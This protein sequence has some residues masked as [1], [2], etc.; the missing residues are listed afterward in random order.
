[1]LPGSRP[2]PVGLPWRHALMAL[3]V[4]LW[5]CALLGGLFL[6]DLW[7]WSAGLLYVGYDTWLIGYVAW[8]TWDLRPAGPEVPRAPSLGVIVPAR[9]EA[10]MLPACLDALLAQ[11]DPAERILLADDGSTDHSAVMLRSRYGLSAAPG[12]VH[13]TIHPGLS[14][15]RLPHGG[16]ARA[17]NAAWPELDTDLVVTLDADTLLAPE[18]LAAL[19]QAFGRDPELAAAGGVLKPRCGHGVNARLFEW[20]Q[21]FEY[22]RAFLSRAA[23]MRAD[24]L[25][26]VSGAFAVFRLEVLRKLGGFRDDSLVEDYELIHRLHRHA[27]D[28]GL[29][30]RVGVVGEARAVTD[31]PASLRSFLRQRRRW[32][33]G[34]LQTQFANRDMTGNP[35]YGAV[36]RLMLPVKTVD[37]L[38][39]LFGLTAF[40]LLLW[41]LASGSPVALPVLLVIGAKLLVD[42]CYHLW[43][44]H[45]YYRWLG[46]PMPPLSWPRA[47]AA[48]LAEP[49]SFQLLRHAGACLGWLSYLTGRLDWSPRQLT[50]KPS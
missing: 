49:F 19:R 41:F 13:S 48:T 29:A 50:G 28:H 32:F 26:L 12:L 4:G 6:E 18:A 35:R 2:F 1:M 20:F 8:R 37:T 15:L 17:L 33:A 43:A 10:A 44:L 9:N 39:P 30:W 24:A 42:F 47:V 16:K 45:L 31:A 36:G 23:W 5:A 21:E 3:L 7:A 11:T 38:Q 40:G 34:F 27:H 14:L 46:T 25:L 22:L